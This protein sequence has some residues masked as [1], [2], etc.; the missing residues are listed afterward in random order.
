[1]A[2]P[3]KARLVS[4]HAK[5]DLKRLYLHSTPRSMK[6][7]MQDDFYVSN[8]IITQRK[9]QCLDKKLWCTHEIAFC[10]QKQAEKFFAVVR[11]LEGTLLS[12]NSSRSIKSAVMS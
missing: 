6:I 12:M 10:V 3:R 8:V 5:L 1:M 9:R 4:N 11:P 2:P 7:E